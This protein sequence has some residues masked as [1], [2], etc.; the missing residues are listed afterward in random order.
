M[1]KRYHS[2]SSFEPLRANV[3][4]GAGYGLVYGILLTA[5]ATIIYATR[6]SSAFEKAGTSFGFTIS[7]YLLGGIC[8]G[9]IV[10]AFKPRLVSRAWSAIAGFVACTPI[11]TA[12]LFSQVNLTGWTWK[13]EALYVVTTAAFLGAGTGLILRSLLLSDDSP[14]SDRNTP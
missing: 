13:M 6:G 11:S 9:G 4:W 10:G 7:L 14:A 2:R 8:A 5:W 1:E 12:F 3:R